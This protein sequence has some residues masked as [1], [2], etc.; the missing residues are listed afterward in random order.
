MNNPLRYYQAGQDSV[1]AM[2]T[3]HE[4]V[5][6]VKAADLLGRAK[7]RALNAKGARMMRY[8]EGTDD[9]ESLVRRRKVAPSEYDQGQPETG[10]TPEDLARAYRT[11]QI[12]NEAARAEAMNERKAA[13]YSFAYGT[14]DVID[15]YKQAIIDRILRGEYDRTYGPGS[16]GATSADMRQKI[17]AYDNPLRTGNVA[18]PPSD[19]A[20]FTPA[21][22]LKYGIADKSYISTGRP[23]PAGIIE[24]YFG[25]DAA[26]QRIP[27]NYASPVVVP[28]R[29]STGAM[30]G[31]PY[32]PGGATQVPTTWTNYGGVGYV[33]NAIP[34][35]QP[36]TSSY[37][38]TIA[39]AGN[40]IGQA[41]RQNAAQQQSAAA[42]AMAQTRANVPTTLG[43][44]EDPWAILRAAAQSAF[45]G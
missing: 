44:I 11:Q 27:P 39:S 28:P 30:A 24:R 15:P 38:N 42:A 29:P 1:P 14:E 25:A 37:G 5:L 3:P 13:H 18:L 19:Y 10:P 21:E 22:R 4:A 35:T 36:A 41:F 45:G 20:L 40:S 33:P 17:G 9:V 6:N 26:S 23:N 12:R 2:L 8:Q 34:V 32:V 31:E 7:I 16:P 43:P